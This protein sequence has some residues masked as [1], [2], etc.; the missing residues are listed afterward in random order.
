MSMVQFV[1]NEIHNLQ[2]LSLVAAPFLLDHPKIG[3]M[4]PNDAIER[5]KHILKHFK[6]GIGAYSDSKGNPLVREEIAK[7][8]EERDGYPSSPDVST[9]R[10]CNT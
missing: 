6:G 10:T 8:I 7:F 4:F 2:V 9:S 3:E 5:A 1:T